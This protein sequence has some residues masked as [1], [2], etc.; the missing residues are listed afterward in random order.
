LKIFRKISF[1]VLGGQSGLSGRT[2]R[3]FSRFI[4]Y[5]RFG[6]RENSLPGGQSVGLRRM[7]RYLPRNQTELCVARVDRAN[8]LRH[9]RGQSAW[10]RRTVRGVLADCPPG[11]RAPLTVVDF[12]FLPLEFKHG[13]SARA[14]RTVR[15]VRIFHITVCNGKGDYKYSMPVLGEPLLAL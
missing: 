1:Q 11:Q 3:G 4:L 6:F 8:G 2:V 14:S 13:Q 5:I 10:P 7:V 9:T 12:A 15:K